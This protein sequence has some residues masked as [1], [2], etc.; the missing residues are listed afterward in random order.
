MT[1]DKAITAAKARA[2]ARCTGCCQQ[3]EIDKWGYWT[4]IDG[5]KHRTEVEAV[6]TCHGDL[7]VFKNGM[8]AAARAGWDCNCDVALN[9]LVAEIERLGRAP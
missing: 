1:L 5:G 7:E 9:E 3:D 4:A 6:H 2:Q 8:L